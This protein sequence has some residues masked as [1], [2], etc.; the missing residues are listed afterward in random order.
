[1]LEIFNH[2]LVLVFMPFLR[3]KKVDDALLI[4]CDGNTVAAVSVQ[5]AVFKSGILVAEP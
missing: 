5:F 1:M 3:D 2:H 4:F